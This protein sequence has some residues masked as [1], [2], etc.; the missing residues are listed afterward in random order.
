MEGLMGWGLDYG[1]THS[2]ARGVARRE[3]DT[4]YLDS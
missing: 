4:G 2:V 1:V 3:S